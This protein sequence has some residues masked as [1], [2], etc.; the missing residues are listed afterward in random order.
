MVR[1]SGVSEYNGNILLYVDDMM[2][3]H[4]DTLYVLM[5]IDKYSKLK[6]NSIGGIDINLGAKLKKMIMANRVWAC[7]NIPATYVRGS[8]KN[9]EICLR[10]LN[11][12]R[13]ELP[14]KTENTFVMGYV[15]DMDKFP[16][17]E[18]DMAS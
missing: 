12:D 3:V 14:K 1:P 16:V 10:G 18:P 4:Y 6:P 2:V 13:W 9:V 7:A 5:K 8:V 11:N 17:L 15:P